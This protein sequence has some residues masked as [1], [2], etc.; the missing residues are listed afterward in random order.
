M[1]I[2]DIGQDPIQVGKF[3]YSPLGQVFNTGL[4]TGER[5]EGLLKRLKNIEGKADNQLKAIEGQKDNELDLVKNQKTKKSDLI[6]KIKFR[7]MKN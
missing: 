6:G 2:L 7:V 3:E 4:T 1:K 5:S